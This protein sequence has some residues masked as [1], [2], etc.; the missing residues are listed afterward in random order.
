LGDEMK[1]GDRV[2]VVRCYDA[3]TKLRPGTRGNVTL[4]DELGTVHVR[5]DDGRNLGLEA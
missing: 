2:E 1:V 4:I 3:Y 5:W